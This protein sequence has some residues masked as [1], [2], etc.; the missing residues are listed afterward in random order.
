MHCAYTLILTR[1]LTKALRIILSTFSHSF[2]HENGPKRCLKTVR[3]FWNAFV[4][5]SKSESTSVKFIQTYIVGYHPMN[6]TYGK[7]VISTTET[8]PCVYLPTYL[9]TVH[10]VDRASVMLDTDVIAHVFVHVCESM[11]LCALWC[12]ELYLQ[13]L[14]NVASVYT[15]IS[16]TDCAKSAQHNFTVLF[17]IAWSSQWSTSP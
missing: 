1:T 7:Y 17:R 5:I 14:Y 8:P 12:T 11:W 4:L 13:Y 9:L 16:E 6:C 3:R 15:L 10:S 2:Y